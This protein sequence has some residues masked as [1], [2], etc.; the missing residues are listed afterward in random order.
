MGF[1]SRAIVPLLCDF[2]LDRP[3]VAK[4]RRQLLAHASGN[5]L[6]IGFGTGLNLPYYSAHVRKLTT[7]DPNV[8]MYRRARRRITHAG[9][10]VDQRVLG[11]ER[12]PFENCTFDCVVSTFTLCSIEDVAQALREVYRVLKAGGRFLFL[13]HG[14]SPH[15]KVQKWQHRLNWLQMR[16]ADG[17]HLDRD[18]RAL[19]TAQPFASAKIDEF[20]IEKTPKT[21]GYMYR[22]IATK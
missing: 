4:Y 7:V 10:E 3:F 2:G 16:L 22:G 5:T 19:V 20:Y 13:E 18:I 14:I 8:G 11:S 15:L 12:L 6:E 17:C 21:H 1:Y 9:I